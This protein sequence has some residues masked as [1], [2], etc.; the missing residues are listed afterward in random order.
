MDRGG[1]SGQLLEH[2]IASTHDVEVVV[3]VFAI[4]Q[5]LEDTVAMPLHRL[6]KVLR[7]HGQGELVASVRLGPT[8][9]VEK[10]RM[11]LEAPP[12]APGALGVT[13]IEGFLDVAERG[14]VKPD[15]TPDR[16]P[17][18]SVDRDRQSELLC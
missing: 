1:P 4:G 10:P 9:V 14:E 11:S 5:L 2:V 12:H 18:L 7:W 6:F 15:L 13:L 3:D 8:E 16:V 17:V